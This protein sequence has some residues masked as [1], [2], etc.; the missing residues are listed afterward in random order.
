[1]KVCVLNELC[2]QSTY[3]PFK[4][5]IS[6]SWW[7]HV[8]LPSSYYKDF[9]GTAR[10]YW[11]FCSLQGSASLLGSTPPQVLWAEETAL[12]A[13]HGWTKWE[14]VREPGTKACLLLQGNTNSSRCAVSDPQTPAAH[15][16][17][18]LLF[19]LKSHHQKDLICESLKPSVRFKVVQR[20]KLNK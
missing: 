20:F 15:I 1:M 3:T 6:N 18:S 16:L 19:L 4:K 11:T 8:V 12:T 10:H 2:I 5:V 17:L 13:A 7:H 14:R 9:S